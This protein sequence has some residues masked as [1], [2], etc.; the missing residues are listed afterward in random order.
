VI[1]A[2]G[3]TTFGTGFFVTRYVNAAKGIRPIPILAAAFLVFILLPHI[4]GRSYL[5]PFCVTYAPFVLVEPVYNRVNVEDTE[6]AFRA[7]YLQRMG[8]D[9]DWRTPCLA[10]TEQANLP[11]ELQA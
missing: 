6:H 3:L 10:Y 4:K 8:R 5:R 2:T 1:G 9:Q 11:R 7:V